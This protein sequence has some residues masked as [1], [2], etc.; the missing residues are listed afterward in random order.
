[1]RVWP[2]S[3]QELDWLEALVQ[4]WWPL[5][6]PLV[7]T[8]TRFHD[9]IWPYERGHFKKLD[10]QSDNWRPIGQG[11]KR[12]QATRDDW[13]TA[14]PTEKIDWGASPSRGKLYGRWVCRNNGNKRDDSSS[15]RKRCEETE[16]NSIDNAECRS[17]NNSGSE[18]QQRVRKYAT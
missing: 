12:A 14:T 2:T 3:L 1:M 6:L 11:L 18:Q 7:S 10:H 13:T 8:V 4:V 15:K 5:E 9:A 16:S 17:P